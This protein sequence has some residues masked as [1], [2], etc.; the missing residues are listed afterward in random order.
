MP[1]A[2]PHS[3]RTQIQAAWCSGG[4]AS[5]IAL[6]PPKEPAERRIL[7]ASD[8]AELAALA[9]GSVLRDWHVVDAS[10]LHRVLFPETPAA[11]LETLLP[12]PKDGEGGPAAPARRLWRLWQKCA[13]RLD[14]IPVWAHEF[15]ASLFTS[16]E[17]PAM[18]AVFLHWAGTLATDDTDRRWQESFPKTVR[19]VERPAL[20]QLTDCTPL[21]ADRAA[22][23]LEQGGAL[24]RLVE[25]YEPR[26]GQI[27]MLKAVAEAISQ[28]NHLLV[29]AGTGIGKSLAYLLPAALWAKLNDVP[30]VI[31]TN[32]KNLQTQLVEKDLP[33]V[34]RV[35]DEARVFPETPPLSAAVIKGRANYLCLRRFAHLMDGGVFELTRPELRMMAAAAVWAV[36]TPD[37]DFDPLTGSG[38]VDPAFVS[39]LSS[40]SDECAGRACRHYG[41]CFV[42]K[43][44]ERALR[45]N[46]VVANH[47]LVFSELSAEQPVSLP[48]HSQL[49]FDEAHNLEEAATHFF[50]VELSPS[51]ISSTLRRLAQKRGRGSRGALYDFQKRFESGAIGAGRKDE[52]KAA[53]KEAHA[54]VAAFNE[55]ATDLFHALHPLVGENES[56]RRY[57]FDPVAPGEPLPAPDARWKAMRTAQTAFEEAL[58]R[59]RQSLV[60]LIELLQGASSADELNLAIGDSNDL[61]AAVGRL[62]EISAAAS[63]LFAGSDASYVYWV[64]PSR[65]PGALGELLA[66]PVNVGDFLA[67]RLYSRLSSIILCS[68]TLSVAG[69]FA[70]ISSRLGRDKIEPERLRTCIAPSPFDYASQCSL[71]VPAYLPEPVAQDRSYVNELSSLVLRLAEKYGGRTMV[72]F[73]SYEMMRQS[74][75]LIR[76]PLERRGLELLL[77]GESGSRNKITRVFREGGGRVLY[78]TQ[79]F[80]EGVD[81]VGDALS[82]VVVAR[83]PFASPADPIVAARC[84]QLEADGVR[85]FFGY[86]MPMAVLRLKQGFGRLIRHRNDRGTVVIADTRLIT[87]GYGRTFSNSLPA[88]LVRCGSFD[89]VISN[90]K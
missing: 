67:R 18:A 84:E 77:Q 70:Y 52:F 85:S 4:G 28:G 80:W 20:P 79:S 44:R 15:L 71:L 13:M 87:K 14:A 22:A 81:V 46:L 45:A 24:S 43:A 9:G 41:R 61:S 75:D 65:V 74:A 40:T 78:G 62:E 3:P 6:W 51:A 48:A 47:S 29:E 60:A 7:F 39:Q 49:I 25:D 42:Q 12:P 89:E 32:T 10:A 11:D 1:S 72:L 5:S 17:E 37:G 64:Q 33:A 88:R 31:S 53:I 56:P 36:T 83:L 57:K 50:T 66:A 86:T 19:R 55:S 38:A 82:C 63:T 16:L 58:V 76:E 23:F 8:G 21:D 30:V 73:T 34:L 59:L 54:A 2:V 68:A 35:M 69:S 90:L 26:P 27:Q